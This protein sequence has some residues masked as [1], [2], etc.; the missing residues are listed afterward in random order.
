MK[1]TYDAVQLSRYLEK[2]LSIEEMN[3]TSAHLKD[4]AT[5]NR[6]PRGQATS[7]VIYNP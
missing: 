4:C 1:C 6:V 2:D 5:C 7:E 3:R